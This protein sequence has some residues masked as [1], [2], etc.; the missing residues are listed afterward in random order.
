MKFLLL[1]AKVF[2]FQTKR[3]WKSRSGFHMNLARATDIKLVKYEHTAAYRVWK[4]LFEWATDHDSV[5]LPPPQHPLFSGSLLQ[6]KKRSNWYIKVGDVVIT[7]ISI[8]NVSLAPLVRINNVL[9]TFEP[10]SCSHPE[11]CEAGWVRLWAARKWIWL[12][13]CHAAPG[14]PCQ[15]LCWHVE[16]Q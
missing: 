3:K 1:Y 11:L 15:V 7:E 2:L 14:R 8:G 16:I 12:Q 5:S 10:P 4:L 9:E 13:I 6:T